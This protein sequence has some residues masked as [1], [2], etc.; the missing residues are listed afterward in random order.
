MKRQLPMLPTASHHDLAEHC[1]YPWNGGVRWLDRAPMA[2][3]Q[4]YGS[5]FHALAQALVTNADADAAG[6]A[7]RFELTLAEARRLESAR[8]RILEVLGAD[9]CARRAAEVAF[10]Y[11]IAASAVRRVT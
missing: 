2:P 7:E 8:D 9:A 5:A 1:V 6:L 4:R 10:V 11:S 3:D